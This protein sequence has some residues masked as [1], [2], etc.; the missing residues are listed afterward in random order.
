M[1]R[2]GGKFERAVLAVFALQRA[3]FSERQR[4]NFS[5]RYRAAKFALFFG[6]GLTSLIFKNLINS[7]KSVIFTSIV[8]FKFTLNFSYILKWAGARIPLKFRFYSYRI[9]LRDINSIRI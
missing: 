2:K 7:L 5:R 1:A 3:E 6:F 9:N 4:Q 8:S